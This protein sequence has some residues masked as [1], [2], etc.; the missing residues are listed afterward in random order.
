MPSTGMN[1]KKMVKKL[2]I[3]ITICYAFTNV[4]MLH[5]YTNVPAFV[6]MAVVMR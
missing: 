5:I 3:I 1:E 4:A 2:I 6:M